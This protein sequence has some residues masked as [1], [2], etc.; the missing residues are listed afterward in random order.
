[1]GK[2]RLTAVKH[3]FTNVSF[4]IVMQRREC[5]RSFNLDQSREFIAA[6]LKFIDRPPVDNSTQPIDID[7][8]NNSVGKQVEN[9]ISIV[10]NQDEKIIELNEEEELEIENIVT[11]GSVDSKEKKEKGTAIYCF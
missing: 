2:Q 9:I 3:N 8:D 1:V 10:K 5:Y 6:L 4:Y 11:K 7:C